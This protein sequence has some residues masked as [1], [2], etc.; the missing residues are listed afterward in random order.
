MKGNIEELGKIK[1]TVAGVQYYEGIRAV[2]TGVELL[3]EREPDNVY[4]KN[5]IRVDNADFEP[6]GHI[7][8][9]H[10]RYLAPLI[11]SGKIGM[12]GCA[13]KVNRKTSELQSVIKVY[14]HE[15]GRDMFE[16]SAVSDTADRTVR[17]IVLQQYHDPPRISREEATGLQRKLLKMASGNGYPEVFLAINLLKWR[18]HRQHIAGENRMREKVAAALAAAN[19]GKPAFHDGLTIFPLYFPETHTSGKIKYELVEDLLAKELAEI[20]EI[21][22]SGSVPELLL[23]NNSGVNALLIDGEE[24]VGAKQNRILNVTVLAAA[25]SETVIPVSCVEQGRWEYRAR[26]FSAGAMATAGMRTRRQAEVK[27][28]IREN[29]TYEADQQSVWEDVGAMNRALEADSESDAMSD[30]YAAGAERIGEFAGALELPEDAH[31]YIACLGGRVLGGDIFG[32]TGPLRRKWPKIIAGCAMETVLQN[33]GKKI[34]KAKKETASAFIEKA[35]GAVGDLYSPPGEG[36]AFSIDAPGIT[37]NALV[38]NE[39]IIHI[40][41]FENADAGVS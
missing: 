27:K 9:V 28:S 40:S 17:N 22:E 33:G 13:V 5:A 31:G 38:A 4:D 26:D 12:K 41:L 25:N 14:K 15:K 36:I 23:K 37:G 1:M 7:P 30:G 18:I 8:R 20:T 35:A 10:A 19:I 32:A 34:K 24:L 11:D 29:G 16:P 6:V 39:E 3:F 21:S 2:E